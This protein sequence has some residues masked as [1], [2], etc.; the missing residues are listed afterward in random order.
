[1]YMDPVYYFRSKG[2]QITLQVI[3]KRM[4]KQ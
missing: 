1:M 4:I 2:G 3:M